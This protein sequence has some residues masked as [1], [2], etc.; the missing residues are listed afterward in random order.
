MK[1]YFTLKTF[2]FLTLFILFLFIFSSCKKANTTQNAPI[3]IAIN[4]WPGYATAFIADS[5]GFFKKNNVNVELILVKGYTE[6]YDL[7]LKGKCDGFFTVLPDVVLL[8]ESCIPT[9]AVCIIDYSTSGDVIIGAPG[10]SNLSDLKGKTISYGGVNSFSHIFVLSAL[11]KAGISET[12]VFFKNLEPMDV[13]KSIEKGEIAGGHTWNPVKSEALIKGCSVLA[14]A[15]NTPN[16]I[17]R[18]LPDFFEA[19]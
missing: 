19:S 5:K 4:I 3:K 16:I 11:E 18:I 14:T 7:Y 13:L 9:K 10:I 2:Y 12:D 6:A 15:E 17:I 1:K 8:N